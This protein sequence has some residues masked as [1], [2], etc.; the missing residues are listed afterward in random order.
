[1][2][3]QTNFFDVPVGTRDGNYVTGISFDVPTGLGVPKAT[4]FVASVGNF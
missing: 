4:A 1:M 2:N 3:Y